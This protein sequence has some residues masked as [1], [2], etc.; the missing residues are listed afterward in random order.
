MNYYK[1]RDI[2]AEMIGLCLIK[3]AERFVANIG[4][5]EG[6]TSEST[7]KEWLILAM[8]ATTHPIPT[9]VA[10]DLYVRVTKLKPVT[11]ITELY[12]LPQHI[13]V[14]F[15]R[16]FEEAVKKLD[17]LESKHNF[18]DTVLGVES[19]QDRIRVAFS[20][21]ETPEGFDY[22]NDIYDR[23]VGGEFLKK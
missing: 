19:A 10:L 23:I 14:K 16:N 1:N 9:S 12:E 7:F 20:W 8:S 2:A 6:I 3:Q 22:W 4:N 17:T 5:A 21:C 11:P 15:W 18:V 13:V